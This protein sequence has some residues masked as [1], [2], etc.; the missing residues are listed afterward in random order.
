MNYTRID[1]YGGIESEH[2]M[3]SWISG[4]YKITV[5]R[6]GFYMAYFIQ[7][8]ANNWGDYVEKPLVHFNP[9]KTLPF[10]GRSKGYLTLKDAKQAVKRHAKRH[11][12]SAGTIKR[13]AEIL[14]S[15]IDKHGIA[16]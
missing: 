13:A 2:G 3:T 1:F 7:N 5:Y 11:K 12:S 16:A 14:E 9:S 10:S 4:I 6:D 15:L 8:Y